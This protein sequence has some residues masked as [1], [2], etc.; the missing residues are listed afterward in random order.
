[1]LDF[2]PTKLFTLRF[3]FSLLTYWFCPVYC[4]AIFIIFVNVQVLSI[5]QH[6][7]CTVIAENASFDFVYSRSQDQNTGFVFFPEKVLRNCVSRFDFPWNQTARSQ[8][9]ALPH[10]SSDNILWT[11]CF[12]D[13]ALIFQ[14][15][16]KFGLSD[17]LVK[18]LIDFF[19]SAVDV[20]DILH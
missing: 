8:I 19:Q 7:Y 9:T 6:T 5:Y 10:P 16:L 12:V 4:V 18:R 3:L 1:M 14:D 15:V 13:G 11:Q 20:I 2:V 17:F